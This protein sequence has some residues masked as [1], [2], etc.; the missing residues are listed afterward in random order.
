MRMSNCQ[1]VLENIQTSK[2]KNLNTVFFFFLDRH[3]FHL[4]L[5]IANFAR[6]ICP[7]LSGAQINL[8]ARTVFRSFDIT[9]LSLSNKIK[10]KQ[11]T[12]LTSYLPEF[13][14]IISQ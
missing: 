11:K 12:Y 7:G 1:S 5:F 3:S 10:K 2:K 4:N 8:L 13:L 9:R 14:S 6:I